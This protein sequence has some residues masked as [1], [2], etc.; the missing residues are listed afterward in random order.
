VRTVRTTIEV[1]CGNRFYV[2]AAIEDARGLTRGEF[3]ED[4]D[5]DLRTEV[6]LAFYQRVVGFHCA[7]RWPTRSGG[8]ESLPLSFDTV[9]AR[10]TSLRRTTFPGR[11]LGRPPLRC[12]SETG[13]ASVQG[14]RTSP[15]KVFPPGGESTDD[16]F[17]TEHR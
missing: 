7:Y 8:C 16:V 14:F 10:V 17:G 1:T 2:E 4:P 13:T 3:H 15:R 9:A 6:L 12:R 5:A 11:R